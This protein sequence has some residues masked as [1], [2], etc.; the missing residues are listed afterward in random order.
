MPE[1]KIDKVSNAL[2]AAWRN[3]G[4]VNISEDLWPMSFEESMAIQDAFDAKINEEIVAWKIAV[5]DPSHF[6]GNR[7]DQLTRPSESETS[8][9]PPG[10]WG[11]YYESV[12]QKSPHIFECRIF[13][14]NSV[15]GRIWDSFGQRFSIRDEPYGLNEITEAVEAV[16][17]TIDVADSRWYWDVSD[18]PFPALH[19][20]YK[21]AA[22]LASGGALVIGDEIP[23][24]RDIDL[25]EVPVAIYSEG[26]IKASRV[27]GQTFSE[28]LAGLHWAVN[29][30][31]QRGFGFQKGHTITTG[32]IAHT[33]AEPGEQA[34][35]RYGDEGEFGEIQITIA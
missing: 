18:W 26:D 35:V 31:R 1:D 13:I 5:T 17:M 3:G 21:G 33:L 23:G 2:A 20:I 19:D 30:L 4:S 14:S 12:T 25:A 34:T 24:W 28:M 7:P 16:V 8:S 6:L 29:L 15:G 9:L 27:R 11:R 10:L 32:A 22:D